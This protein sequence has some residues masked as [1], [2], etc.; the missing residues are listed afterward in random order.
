ML[1]KCSSSPLKRIRSRDPPPEKRPRSQDRSSIAIGFYFFRKRRLGSRFGGRYFLK[2]G[3][4]R[5]FRGFTD[6]D[7]Q[8]TLLALDAVDGSLGDQIAVE[9]NGARGIIIARDRVID[10][11]WIAVRVENGDHR[12]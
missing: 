7:A 3:L 4:G 2:R 1:L 6:I 9:R 10:H 12:N 5:R 11:I 8:S